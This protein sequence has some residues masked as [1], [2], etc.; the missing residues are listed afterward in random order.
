[1]YNRYLEKKLEFTTDEAILGRKI[2]IE[3]EYYLIE[4]NINDYNYD[5]GEK[6]Y[7]IEIVKKIDDSKFESEMLKAISPCIED[8]RKLL[9]KLANNTV[10]PIEMPFV[11]D[12]ILAE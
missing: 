4:S 8:T 1:M 2:P 5:L 11:M 7:G 9:N 6:E 10:T 12:D 3:L